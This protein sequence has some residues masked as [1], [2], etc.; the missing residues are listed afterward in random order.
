LK[1]TNGQPFVRVS[2]SAAFTGVPGTLRKDDPLLVGS[3]DRFF[4]ILVLPADEPSS[5]LKRGDQL[6]SNGQSNRVV[7][8]DIDTATGLVNAIVTPA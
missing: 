5:P 7:R 6:T 3:Q 2:D 4:L 1:A 8:R